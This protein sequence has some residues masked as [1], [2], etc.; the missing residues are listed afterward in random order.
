MTTLLNRN[1]MTTLARSAARACRWMLPCMVVAASAMN[2][3]AQGSQFAFDVNG[4][5]STQTNVATGLPQIF[6]QPR[7]Q[8]VPPGALATFFVVAANTHNLAY[9]WRFNGTD[10]GGATGDTLLLANVS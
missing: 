8:I 10:M 6:N 1:V 2:S 7:Q 4:N 9:Q 3:F 5:L